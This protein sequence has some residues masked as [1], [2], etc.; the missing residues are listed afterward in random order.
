MQILQKLSA[1]INRFKWRRM[2][3]IFIVY[4]ILSIFFI[5]Y[6]F[7]MQLINK[8]DYF[9]T[10]ITFIA[11]VILVPISLLGLFALRSQIRVMEVI[12]QG[13]GIETD[14]RSEAEYSKIQSINVLAGEIRS[15]TARIQELESEVE[16]LSLQILKPKS[17]DVPQKEPEKKAPETHIESTKEEGIIEERRQSLRTNQMVEIN[18]KDTESFI[19]AYIVNVGGGGL[20]IKTEDPVELN[21]TLVVR[22]YLPHDKEPITAE[23]KV[24]WVTPKGVK[25]PSYPPGLGL[26]F[27]HINPEDKHRLD[28]FVTK[29]LP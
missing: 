4:S 5:A 7:V 8:A 26:K 18:F 23:G 13:S 6:I 15:K 2:W 9:T 19:K 11:I 25:N 16:R 24:V 28:E 17:A 22:F 1:A 21:E 20:F 3:L 10:L 14:K 12:L 29:V 27:T